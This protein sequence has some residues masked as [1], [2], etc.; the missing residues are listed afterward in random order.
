MRAVILFGMSGST[1]WPVFTTAMGNT[2]VNLSYASP[3]E[4]TA[5]T[6]VLSGNTFTVTSQSNA[7]QS[8]FTYGYLAIAN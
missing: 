8:G 6:T 1:R 2:G 4:F 5:A 7:Q 3:G